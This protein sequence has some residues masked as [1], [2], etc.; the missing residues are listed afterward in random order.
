[1]WRLDAS[2]DKIGTAQVR[3]RGG[4][5]RPF[6]RWVYQIPSVV[7]FREATSKIWIVSSGFCK[8]LAN[9]LSY[10]SEGD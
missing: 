3:W 5:V 1:M 4:G 7:S 9:H 2:G 10:A 8:V 6:V